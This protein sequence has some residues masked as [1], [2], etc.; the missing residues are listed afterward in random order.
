MSYFKS[1]LDIMR[2]EKKNRPDETYFSIK[3]PD[4]IK[5]IPKSLIKQRLNNLKEKM[6]F[7]KEG[8]CLILSNSFKI[9]LEAIK[10][11]CDEGHKE[12]SI[13]YRDE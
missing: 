8:A 10:E 6:G 3:E 7:T 4:G 2:D 5:L 11:A 1:G 13:S 12:L 9:D